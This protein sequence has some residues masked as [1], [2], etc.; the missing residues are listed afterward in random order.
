MISQQEIKTKDNE[1]FIHKLTLVLVAFFA[2]ILLPIQT[3][4]ARTFNPSQILDDDEMFGENALSKTA[5]QRFLE[6]ENS[7]LARFSQVV[8]GGAKKASEIVWEIGQKH[9]V[10]SKFL[11]ATLEKEQGLLHVSQATEKALDWATGYSCFGG[12]C[13]EKHRGFYNQVEATAETQDIYRQRSSQFGFRVGVTTKSFDGLEVTPQNQATANLYIYTPYVGYSPELGVTK[14]YGGN[15]LLWRIWQRYFTKQKF[16]D[17]QTITDGSNYWLVQNNTKRKFASTEIFTADYNP[18]VAIKATATDLAAYPDG[19]IVSFSNN[20][21]VK[22]AASGQIFL[23]ADNQKRPIVDNAALALLSG[24][25]IAVAESEVTTVTEDTLAPY[26]LGSF[27]TTTSVYPQGKLFRDETG[28]IWQV[29]DGLKHLVDPIVWQ[30]RFGSLEPTAITTAE[31]ASYPTG[32]PALLKDGTF[33]RNDSGVYYLISNGERM[34]V[35]DEGIFSR[36]FGLNKKSGALNVST[37]L[38]EAHTAGDIID[39]A[40]ETIQD[41]APAVPTTPTAPASSFAASFGSMQPDGLVMVT[42]ASAPVVVSFKNTGSTAWQP[43]DVWLSVT[44][45]GTASSSFGA[46]EKINFNESSIA[47]G[48][49]ATFTVNLT[50]PTD[51]SGLLT[52]EFSLYAGGSAPSKLASVGKFIIVNA[53]DAAMVT[54]HTIPVAVRHTWKPVS[55]VVKVKNVSNDTT[56]L[57]RKTALE[58]YGADGSTS[59]FYDPNDWVRQEV[60]A[61]PLNKTTIKPGEVGEFKFTLDPRGIKPG[62]YTLNVKLK[63]LDKDKQV[64]LNGKLEWRLLIRVD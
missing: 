38:L 32:S 48:Q 16:L 34:K 35:A 30:N 31:L 28:T 61:V 14:P 7:V 19:P 51:R 53:G 59:P 40:D 2:L 12:S 23:L 47:S 22:S 56:W 6:R 29:Q 36:V 9:D 17:G 43:G 63:L 54:E 52:Q 24:V 11:L 3:V 39:Y 55:V 37:A 60:A 15:R 21:L 44:D 18:S 49:L 8:D 20:T 13:N 62:T 26:T 64:Y 33:V 42:G 41:A 5:I 50:A 46:P 10:N 25:R 1:T 58:I 27:I 45:R 4:D 57:S